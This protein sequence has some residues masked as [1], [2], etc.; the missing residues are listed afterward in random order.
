MLVN[1]LSAA[2]LY[3]IQSDASTDC[4]NTEDELLV[5]VYFDAHANDKTKQI[6]CSA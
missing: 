1:A 3:S 4:G 5:V 6:F 2:K